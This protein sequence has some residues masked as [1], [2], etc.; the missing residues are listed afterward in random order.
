MPEVAEAVELRADLSQLA[1]DDLV[2]IHR[3]VL[4]GH[5]ERLRDAEAVV[6]RAVHRH[7]GLVDVAELIDRGPCGSAF[8]ASSTLAGVMPVRRAALIVG[9]PS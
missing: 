9:A 2:V 6:A 7:A 3:L 1:A 8:F 4:P 5:R